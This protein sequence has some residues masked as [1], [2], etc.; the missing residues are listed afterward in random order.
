MPGV[1][2]DTL[3]LEVNSSGFT[4]DPYGTVLLRGVVVCVSRAYSSILGAVPYQRA[5]SHLKQGGFPTDCIGR[6]GALRG[7]LGRDTPRRVE[8]H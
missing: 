4:R 8:K 2:A 1:D 5:F 6:H 3:Q 7:V